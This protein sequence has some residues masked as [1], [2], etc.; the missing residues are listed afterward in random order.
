[1]STITQ[2]NT[3]IECGGRIRQLNIET[4][5]EE[6][7]LVLDEDD[8]DRGPEWRSTD[9]EEDRRRTGSPL[10]RTRHDRGLSTEI[11]YG[12]GS[13]VRG[14]R[15]RQLLRMRRQHSRAKCS[16]KS[17]RNRKYANI[18]IKRLVGALGLADSI[19][20]QA[21][22]LFASAQSEDLLYGRSLEG[23]AAAVVYATCRIQSITR[24]MDEITDVARADKGELKVAYDAMNR[25]LGLPVGPIDP[26]EYIPRFA[27]EL[28]LDTPVENAARSYLSELTESGMV[29]GK[30]PSGVAAACLYKAGIDADADVTQKDAAA[31]ADVSPMTVRSTVQDIDALQTPAAGAIT[32]ATAD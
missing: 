20:E 26:A 8:V 24:T 5:C 15:Q 29:G 11:G 10:T 16:S 1:M 31:V 32:T 4:V 27:T 28:D 13:D 19:A 3:C 6:C 23:F 22:A 21:C 2:T 25:E 12:S 9:G 17:D 18:E 14:E 7:G 30:N